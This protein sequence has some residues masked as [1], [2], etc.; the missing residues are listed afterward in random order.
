[1]QY[2]CVRV[3]LVCL[4]LFHFITSKAIDK[5]N[6]TYYEHDAIRDHITSLY[7]VNTKVL[8]I[9]K[10]IQKTNSAYLELHTHNSRW[11]NYQRFV[12]TSQRL[13]VRSA[14][15]TTD[16]ETI[17]HGPLLHQ[18]QRTDQDSCF[19]KRTLSARISCTRRKWILGRV[20]PCEI[21]CEMHVA[22]LLQTLS[23]LTVDHTNFS[24]V[25]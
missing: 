16:V 6:E 20:V 12:H 21:V 25:G 9:F 8:Y 3:F 10:M 11:K 15:H 14:N 23:S 24:V 17:I 22:P 4:C 2:Y 7:R 19:C 18:T 13:D 1:M 5:Y